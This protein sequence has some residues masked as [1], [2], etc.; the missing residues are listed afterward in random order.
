MKE[1]LYSMLIEPF[2]DGDGLAIFLGILMWIVSGVLVLLVSWGL[3]I[4]VDSTFMPIQEKDGL[5]VGTKYSPPHDVTTYNKIGDVMVPNTVHY[6]ESFYAVVEIDS[7]QDDI[8]INGNYYYSEPRGE[9]VHCTYV[10]GR[11]SNDLYIKT[12]TSK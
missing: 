1:F 5:V 12:I 4:L 6:D 9:V 11:I 8:Q 10:R 3:F 2:T 7:L